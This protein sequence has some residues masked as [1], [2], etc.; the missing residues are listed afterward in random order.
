MDNKAMAE[1]VGY[2]SRAKQ[3]DLRYHFIRDPVN[4]GST[5]QLADFMTKPLQT[6][7]FAKLAQSAGFVDKSQMSQ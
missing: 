2:Q 6:P 3:I 7:Q 5:Q 1:R 4:D